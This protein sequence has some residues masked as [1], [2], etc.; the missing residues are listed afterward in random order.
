MI[1]REKPCFIIKKNLQKSGTT[2]I[3]FSDSVTSQVLRDV[4]YKILK[5]NEFEVQYVDNDYEDEY[6]QRTIDEGEK[7]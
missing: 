2:G 6:M 7:K 5:V 1:Y 4:C 3:Y